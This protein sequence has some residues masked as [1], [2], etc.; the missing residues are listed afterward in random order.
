MKNIISFIKW[1]FSK[2]KP[3]DYLWFLAAAL[4]GAG[5]NSLNVLFHIGMAM[6]LLLSIV[7]LVKMQWQSWKEERRNLLNSIKDSDK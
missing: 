6:F 5:I 2:Y 3:I 4:I 7:A 1:Q